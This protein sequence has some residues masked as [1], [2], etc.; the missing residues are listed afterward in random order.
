MTPPGL[1]H[2][3]QLEPLDPREVEASALAPAVE[4]PAA[5]TAPNAPP[6][7]WKLV[8]SR[9][10]YWCPVLV[11]MVLFAQIAFSGLRPAMCENRRLEDAEVV[12]RAR[13]ERDVALAQEIFAHWR[14]R[15][16]PIFLERQRRLRERA[17]LVA[18]QD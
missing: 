6:S 14:A 8:G 16:D 18:E 13:H 10:V 1:T 12:L 17:P 4:A 11:P 15:Q 5:V 7:R 2:E 9:F 3:P